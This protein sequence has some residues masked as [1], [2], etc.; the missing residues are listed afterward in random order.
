M[1]VLDGIVLLGLIV[2]FLV[3]GLLGESKTE[4]TE[5]YFLAGRKLKWH[6]IGFSLFATNFSASGLIGITGAAYVIGIAIYNYEWVGILAMVFFALVMVGVVR[7]SRVFTIAQY[8]TER[9]DDRVKTLYSIFII[10]LLVFIDMAASLYAGGLLLNQF[11]PE[12][13]MNAVIVLVMLMSGLYS[14]VGGMT[15]I[16]RTDMYQSL[17]LI[18]GAFMIAYF[19]FSSVGGWS[20]FLQTAPKGSLNLIRG[21]DDRAVPWTGLVTGIP[22]IGAYYWLVNQNMVQWVLG[23]EDQTHARRGLFFAGF[24]KTLGLFVIVLPG[25][26]AISLIPGLTEPDRIYPAML[27]ELLPAGILGFVLA[28]FVS[29]LMSNTDST[30]HAASTLV[31][32]D[33][34]KPRRPDI[35][36]H[37]LVRVGRIT[38]FLI[39]GVSAVWAPMIGNFGTLFEYVQSVLSYAV[40]PFVVVYLGGMFWQRANSKGAIAALGTGLITATFIGVLGDGIGLFHIHYLHVPLPIGLVSLMTLIVVSKLTTPID[41]E[42]RL[43]WSAARSLETTQ[44]NISRDRRIAFALILLT[45]TTVVLFR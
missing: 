26:A 40:A 9:Y 38:T 19:S 22:I 45:I 44:V 4:T 41:V 1:S 39:I 10:L 17:I 8:L 43:M 2:A 24:L 14:V 34:V 20:A 42:P 25:I 5:D 30:L 6:Q 11:I 32:M 16:S 7:G 35:S 15:A 36:P 33:F 28:G 3:I 18:L 12:I 23:A 29:A 31:T 27:V 37:H 21:L 13:S